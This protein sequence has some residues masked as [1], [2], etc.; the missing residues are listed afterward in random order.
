MSAEAKQI[1]HP[2]EDI[3]TTAPQSEPEVWRMPEPVFR[4]TSGKLPKAF[5]DQMNE[6]I[7]SGDDVQAHSAE[8]SIPVEPPSTASSVDAAPVV[9]PKSDLLKLVVVALA[10][11]AMIAFIVVLVTVVYFLFL[12]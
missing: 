4:R 8:T 1:D 7:S 3:D 11:G 10:L 9:K 2:D 12:R 6:T 5:V